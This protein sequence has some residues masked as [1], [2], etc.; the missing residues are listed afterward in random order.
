VPVGFAPNPTG[1]GYWVVWP[2]GEVEAKG[3]GDAYGDAT[4]VPLQQVVGIADHV[5]E[6]LLA[7]SRRRRD[8]PSA[9]RASDRPAACVSINR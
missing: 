7:R 3:R 9:A 8:F 1:T 4:N 2:N 6:G 5:R